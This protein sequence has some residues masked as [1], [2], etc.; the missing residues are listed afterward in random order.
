MAA[1]LRS[2]AIIKL[3]GRNVDLTTFQKKKE[4]NVDHTGDVLYF[5]NTECKSSMIPVM[6]L[7]MDRSVA[8]SVWYH[9]FQRTIARCL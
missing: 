2:F 4:K 8:T 6:D 9:S 1:A 3:R 5:V 7:V